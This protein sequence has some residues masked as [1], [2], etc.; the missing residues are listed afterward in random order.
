MTSICK[1][2]DSKYKKWPLVTMTWT[3]DTCTDFYWQ[4]H[5]PWIPVLISH[6]ND[7]DCAYFDWTQVAMTGT[8]ILVLFSSCNALDSEYFNRPLVPKASSLHTLLTSSGN[9]WVSGYFYWHL[10]TMTGTL[11]NFTDILWQWCGLCIL[12]LT[13]IVNDKD[14]TF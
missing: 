1:G 9:T 11:N 14:S 3:L 13:T 4:W 2:W 8:F 5:R 12:L 10:V 7:R 6:G